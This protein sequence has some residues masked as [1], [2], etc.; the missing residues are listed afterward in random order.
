MKKL[1]SSFAI[2]SALLTT[3]VSAQAAD[4]S[5]QEA[6]KIAIDAYHTGCG[7]A[8]EVGE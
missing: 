8:T 1:L 7:A 6:K 5:P 4:L 2:A 3:W